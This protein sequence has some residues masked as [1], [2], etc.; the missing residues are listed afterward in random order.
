[1]ILVEERGWE[2]G[3]EAIK[4]FV[5]SAPA[6]KHELINA[7]ENA[8]CGSSIRWNVCQDVLLSLAPCQVLG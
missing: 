1:M 2:E 6:V 3:F 4:A 7:S 5:D 8:L